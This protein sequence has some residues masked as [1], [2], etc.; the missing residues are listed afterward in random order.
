MWTSSRGERKSL[1]TI[2]LCGQNFR[3]DC[4]RDAHSNQADACSCVHRAKEELFLGCLR[5]HVVAAI[6]FNQWVDDQTAIKTTQN[7]RA[8]RHRRLPLLDHQA[9]ALL[10]RHW[11]PSLLL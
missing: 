9:F 8:R 2:P 10:T 5:S 3:S 6:L 4:V 1:Q 7:D 11:H